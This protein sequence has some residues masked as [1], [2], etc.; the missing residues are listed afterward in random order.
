MESRFHLSYMDR[1]MCSVLC[2]FS[3]SNAVYTE[4]SQDH[5]TQFACHLQL[6]PNPGFQRKRKNLITQRPTQF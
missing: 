5:P 4:F 6:L 1:Q 2:Y 3:M